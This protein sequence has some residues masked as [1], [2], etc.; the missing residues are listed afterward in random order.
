MQVQGNF[1]LLERDR[2]TRESQRVVPVETIKGWRA[3]SEFD[4]GNH[5]VAGRNVKE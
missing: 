1:Q 3:D 4:S 5:F 2:R